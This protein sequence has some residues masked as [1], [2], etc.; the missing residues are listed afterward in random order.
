MANGLEFKG[1]VNQMKEKPDVICIQESWL[2]PG[3][4]FVLKGYSAV[5]RDREEGNGGGCVTFI[6]KGVQYRKVA[7]GKTSEYVVVEVWDQGKKYVIINVYD[8]CKRLE[9]NELEKIEGQDD[10]RV[11]W[12]SG[13][14]NKCIFGVRICIRFNIGIWS[15]RRNNGMGDFEELHYG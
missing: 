14:Q 6:G 3:L 8:P 1:Y 5:R 11:I 12:L 15:V 13:Y 10:E 7:I 2:K 4:D 9:M